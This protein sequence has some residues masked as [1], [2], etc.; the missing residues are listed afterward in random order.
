M[1][2]NKKKSVTAEELELK[3]KASAVLWEE[4]EKRSRNRKVYT[5]DGVEKEAVYYANGA[6]MSEEK[7]ICQEKDG[8]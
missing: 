6:Q 3:E 4:V 2:E 5:R 1:E 7:G 8:C